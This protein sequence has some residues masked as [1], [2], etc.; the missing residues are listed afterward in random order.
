VPLSA[1]HLLLHQER[2]G[3]LLLFHHNCFNQILYAISFDR[4]RSKKRS[5]PIF[6]FLPL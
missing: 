5:S 2:L 4:P 1:Q 3:N 6:N